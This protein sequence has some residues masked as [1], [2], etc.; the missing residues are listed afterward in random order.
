MQRL[1]RRQFLLLGASSA[2]AILLARWAASQSP[3]QLD[4][5]SPTPKQNASASGLVDMSLDA[6]YEAVNVA[7]QQAYLFS[8]NGQV[9]DFRHIFAVSARL[10]QKNSRQIYAWKAG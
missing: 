6:R 2:G 5:P 8:Y 3:P 4:N 9:C 1:N 7:G 10:S